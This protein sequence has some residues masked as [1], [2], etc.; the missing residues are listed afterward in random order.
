MMRRD[1]SWSCTVDDGLD[2]PSSMKSIVDVAVPDSAVV[3]VGG[4]LAME[5]VNC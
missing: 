4:L 5:L 3:A 1:A 2:P